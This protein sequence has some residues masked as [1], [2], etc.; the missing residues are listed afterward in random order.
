LVKAS[1]ACA[2]SFS[3]LPN[4]IKYLGAITMTIHRFS[5]CL[6]LLTFL[7][8]PLTAQSQNTSVP[9]ESTT[10]GGLARS[11]E[12]PDSI[13][14]IELK[15]A[16]AKEIEAALTKI[17]DTKTT[18]GELVIVVDSRSN[19]LIFR[20]SDQLYVKI[21]ELVSELDKDSP[22]ES[23]TAISISGN[24]LVAD[25]LVSSPWTPNSLPTV[26][27]KASSQFSE[28]RALL[29]A[30]KGDS[31]ELKSIRDAMASTVKQ[32][33][34]MKQKELRSELDAL[35]IKM[36]SLESLLT[37]REAM[38]EQICLKRMDSLLAGKP[39]PGWSLLNE[40]LL[41][42]NVPVQSFFTPKRQS[43]L[44]SNV[45]LTGDGIA[46][47][48]TSILQASLTCDEDIKVILGGKAKPISTGI[49]FQI[50]NVT[51]G[52]EYELLTR[53]GKHLAVN[54]KLECKDAKQ[55]FWERITGDDIRINIKKDEI[56]RVL[57]T[58][59]VVKTVYFPTESGAAMNTLVSYQME[60]GTDVLEKASQLGQPILTMR[61]SQSVGAL[62]AKNE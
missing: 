39:L 3:E 47:E 28:Y 19:R 37:K 33:F 29:L 51:G 60:P 57:G 45:S 15:Y 43:H 17:Y 55:D 35:R 56:E 12:T 27:S 58:Q 13:H 16:N 6:L 62:P 34:V 54:L 52:V 9:Q 61:L 10:A 38:K 30:A 21:R 59:M 26:A 18:S 11:V 44:N 20:T 36:D 22:V 2:T 14:L 53:D 23:S 25:P 50:N 7:S 46:E 24:P 31:N 32:E 5:K 42:Q 1:T 48:I 40:P 8:N 41:D 49:T 4:Y